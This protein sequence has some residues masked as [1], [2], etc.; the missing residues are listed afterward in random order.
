M[1]KSSL[2]SNQ[3]PTMK[4]IDHIVYAVRDLEEGI[5]NIESLF[6]IRPVYGGK[7]PDQGTHNALLNLGDS[8][9]FEIIAIDPDNKNIPAPL[10]M[11]VNFITKPCIT[12]WAIKT[13]QLQADTQ[14]LKAVNPDLGHTKTG[15]RKREDGTVLQWELSIPLAEPAIEG[16]P[17]L[18]DW[19]AGVHPTT[20]LEEVC[21]LLDFKI[22]HPEA[23]ALNTILAKLNYQEIAIAENEIRLE[24]KVQTPNGIVVLS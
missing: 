24:L 7:H 13:D 19:E 17:F 5:N 4:K 21:K 6:G 14:I 18:L 11:G 22:F 1:L 12:R 2:E 20:Q 9:Y 3:N 16:I 10:W 8:C 23:E 15:R